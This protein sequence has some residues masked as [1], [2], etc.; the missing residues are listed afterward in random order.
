MPAG[1]PLYT[2]AHRRISIALQGLARSTDVVSMIMLVM[3]AAIAGYALLLYLQREQQLQHHTDEVR[4][5]SCSSP[6]ALWQR[7]HIGKGTSRS[8]KSDGGRI[9]FLQ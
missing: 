4:L 3:A 2:L 8:P 1:A 5:V 7:N 6:A 9:T